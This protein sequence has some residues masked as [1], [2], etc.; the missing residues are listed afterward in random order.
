MS[1]TDAT[2]RH[3]APYRVNMLDVARLAGVSKSTVSRVLHDDTRIT[4]KTRQRV[5]EAIE[6]LGYKP[7]M[8]VHSVF[9]S[10][11]YNVG[12]MLPSV[13]QEHWGNVLLGIEEQAFEKGYNIFIAN[14]ALSE[15]AEEMARSD[16]K[17]ERG[18][19]RFL[20]RRVDGLIIAPFHENIANRY[21]TQLV[22]IGIPLVLLD[23]RLLVEA[24]LVITDDVNG[25]RQAGEHLIKLGHRRI[26]MV[27]GSYETT[28]GE[29][30]TK[31]FLDAMMAS[32]VAVHKDL[33]IHTHFYNMPQLGYEAALKLLKR[34]PRPTAIFAHTD[35]HA[36][37]VY[38]AAEELGLKIPD[39]VSVV[40]YAD[41]QFC[42]YMSPALT[43]VHQSGLN[44][45]RVAFNLLCRHFPNREEG[46]RTELVP[47]RLIVRNSTRKI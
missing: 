8:L 46:H 34:R 39:D 44:V 32:G 41:L 4:K 25:A 20:Q 37:G 12:V 5:Q 28:T 31:G 22:N 45:G 30:R 13:C 14:T 2:P 23:R 1:S 17:E 29:M 36:V 19:N 27:G 15:A 21:F 3:N 35:M 18:L 16:D 43:T 42:R 38:R 26:G 7:N 10:R 9:T 6:R 33:L 47:T 11:T 40:G 24:D